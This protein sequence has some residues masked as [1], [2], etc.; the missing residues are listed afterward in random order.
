[1]MCTDYTKI[2]PD[3]STVEKYRHLLDA[4]DLSHAEVAAL[5]RTSPAPAPAD[6]APTPPAHPDATSW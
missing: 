4:P 6:P 5:P 3:G 2:V 1:M